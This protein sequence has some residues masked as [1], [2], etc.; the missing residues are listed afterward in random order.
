MGLEGAVR[1]AMRAELEAIADVSERERVVAELTEAARARS[2]ALN[3]ARH[4]ELDDVVDPAETR[5]V[6]ARLV[7]AAAR[8]G[9]LVGS[10]RTVDTW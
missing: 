3:V 1:L 10:G 2:D 8:D 9:R 6:L 7:D 5:T 4:G